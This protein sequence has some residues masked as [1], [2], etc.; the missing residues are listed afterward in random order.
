MWWGRIS[1]MEKKSLIF[2][3]VKLKGYLYIIVNHPNKLDLF[4]FE[5]D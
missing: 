3:R 2:L 1:Q 4:G 5:V